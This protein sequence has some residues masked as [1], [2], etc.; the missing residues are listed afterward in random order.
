VK[1]DAVEIDIDTAIPLGLIANELIVNACKYAFHPSGNG[2]LLVSLSRDISNKL[3]FRVKDNGK[4][5][6]ADFRIDKTDTLGLKLV[7]LLVRQLKG[8]IRYNN[9]KGTEFIITF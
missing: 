8:D 2:E 3:M 4:G 6:P 1:C 9:H 5:M 7:S